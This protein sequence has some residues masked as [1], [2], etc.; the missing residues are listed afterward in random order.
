MALLIN[1]GEEVTSRG[2]KSEQ[3]HLING[4]CWISHAASSAHCKWFECYNLI[5]EINALK[6]YL[7]GVSS[8]I[9]GDDK[10]LETLEKGFALI[11]KIIEQNKKLLQS[12]KLL[13]FHVY[14][15]ELSFLC[16]SFITVAKSL[17]ST[18]L[19]SSNANRFLKFTL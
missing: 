5:D 4:R 3:F 15:C 6:I 19:S 17:V 14:R 11:W 16:F 9:N 8:A 1:L 2:T 10:G 7:N 12:M 18:M 13:N